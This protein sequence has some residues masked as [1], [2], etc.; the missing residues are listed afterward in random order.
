ME[1]TPLKKTPETF[2]KQEIEKKSEKIRVLEKALTICVPY[3]A[4]IG[5]TATLTGTSSNLIIKANIDL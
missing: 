3:A 4:L 2:D 1:T 5:G